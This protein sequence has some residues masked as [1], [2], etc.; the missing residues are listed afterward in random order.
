MSIIGNI[1]RVG[2]FSSS[3]IFRLVN[4][5]KTFSS[6]VSEKNMERRLGRSLSIEKSTRP[7]I[8]GHF[9]ELYV[10]ENKL[11]TAYELLSDTTMVHPEF[12]YWVGTPDNVNRSASV[13]GDTKCFEPKAFCEYVDCISQ[14]DVELFK[15]EYPKEYWQLVSN[16]CILNMKYIEP[17]AYMPYLS[18]LPDIRLAAANTEEW[19][20]KFIA[21]SENTELAWL[22]DNSSYKDLNIIRFEV[23]QADKDLLTETVIKA[24][25]QLI[26]P[27]SHAA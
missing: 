20:Y 9:L 25:K 15:A 8:W 12:S 18:E 1:E 7:M 21:E 27:L 3:E 14:N 17:I 24:G 6:Y 11:S 4:S 23:P 19:K 16:A 5:A 13:V 10:H 2:N 26:Q 22:P